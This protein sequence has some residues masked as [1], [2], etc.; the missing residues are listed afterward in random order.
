M[1]SMGYTEIHHWDPGTR[2]TSHLQKKENG[3]HLLLSKSWWEG[4]GHFF[5][6]CV[7]ADKI[8]KYLEFYG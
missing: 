2:N 7:G 8:L 4:R 3:F 5:R 1:G 6:S